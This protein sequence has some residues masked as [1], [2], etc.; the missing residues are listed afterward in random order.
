MAFMQ[1]EIVKADFHTGESKYGETTVAPAD[2]YGTIEKF[3]A[4]CDLK[5]DTCE[6]IQG[7]YW[8]RYSAPGYLDCTDW[9]GP[10]D[11]VSACQRELH[12]AYGDEDETWEAES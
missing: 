4:F 9:H 8:G 3:A 2:V 11:S 7:K 5:V 12:D 10:F 1:P 6:V